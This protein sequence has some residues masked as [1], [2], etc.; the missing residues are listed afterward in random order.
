MAIVRLGGVNHMILEEVG[1][2]LKFIILEPSAN[3][4]G[5]EKINWPLN[6]QLTYAL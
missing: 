6:F 4:R 2:L 5:L 3:L 1:V